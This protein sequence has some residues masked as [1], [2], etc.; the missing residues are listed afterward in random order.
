MEDNSR[1]IIFIGGCSQTKSGHGGETLKNIYFVEYLK[2]IGMEVQ[3]FDTV[4]MKKNPFLFFS[5]IWVL[6][7]RKSDL[8]V[9]AATH[10]ALSL[11][12]IIWLL[13]WGKN[14]VKYFVI[15]GTIGDR[16]KAGEINPKILRRISHIY[17]ETTQLESRLKEIGIKN[18]SKIPNFKPIEGKLKVATAT[19]QTGFRLVYVSRVVESKGIFVL[20]DV[21]KKLLDKYILELDIY[22]PLGAEVKNRF[23]KAIKGEAAIQYHGTLDF[24]SDL[25]AYVKLSEYQLMVLPTSHYGEGFPG[26]FIDCFIAGVPVLTT[27]W[28][29]NSEII[30][31]GYNGFLITDARPEIL[32]QKLC[33]LLESPPDW[34]QYKENC[35]ENARQYDID[36][37]LNP[38]FV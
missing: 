1:F 18:V 31:D 9:S 28:N 12:K 17:V 21:V 4:Q 13:G 29:S 10:T 24:Y 25:G 2:K 7:F 14:E 38:I 15:G 5:L 19:K 6:A 23:M 34:V 20:I 37:V 33:S 32:Y 35:R 27:D 3:V 22:G 8:V 11:F 36:F 26:V 30:H 16:V